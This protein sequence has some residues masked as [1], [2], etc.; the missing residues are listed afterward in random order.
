M[1]PTPVRRLRVNLSERLAALESLDDA[2]IAGDL[3]VIRLQLTRAEGKLLRG[4]SDVRRELRIIEQRI[5]LAERRLQ[6]AP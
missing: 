4:Q 3:D 2:R 5:A 1:L 6:N